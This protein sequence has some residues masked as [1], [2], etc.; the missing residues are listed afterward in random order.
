MP[1]LGYVIAQSVIVL[2]LERSYDQPCPA[3]STTVTHH[4]L[5]DWTPTKTL[6][7]ELLDKQRI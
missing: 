4:A 6:C 2:W 7:S 3:F 1:A 5:L